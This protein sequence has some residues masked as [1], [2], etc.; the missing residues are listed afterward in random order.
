MPY[1]SGQQ[2]LATL[3][4]ADVVLQLGIVHTYQDGAGDP[5]GVVA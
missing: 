2:V 3:C 5:C 4:A 1:E